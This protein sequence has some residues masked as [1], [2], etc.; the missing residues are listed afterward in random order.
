M[1]DETM[2]RGVPGA[3][4]AVLEPVDKVGPCTAPGTSTL[5]AIVLG[6]R[7]LAE[8]FSA[9]PAKR[10]SRLLVL[11]AG[12]Q[13]ETLDEVVQAYSA[14]PGT[15]CVISKLDE[16]VKCGA[17]I[18]VGIRHRLLF[19]G[20]ANGQRV[21]QDWHAARAPLLAQK[22]LMKPVSDRYLPN[23]AE[24]GLLLTALPAAGAGAHGVHC[25]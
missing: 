8:L 18:D 4:V 1:A 20:F 5:Q 2:G 6:D 11:N 25:A 16:A 23:D 13:G 7:R 15:R 10:I 3:Q 14:G 19:E 22:A 21:P 12:A 9:L 17:T 24:L